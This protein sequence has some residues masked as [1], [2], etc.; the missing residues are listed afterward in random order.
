VVSGPTSVS[1]ITDRVGGG[2][3]RVSA[4]ALDAPGLRWE[5][6]VTLDEGRG[7]SDAA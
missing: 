5:I 7:K 3:Y 1:E 6:L 2:E 4:Y